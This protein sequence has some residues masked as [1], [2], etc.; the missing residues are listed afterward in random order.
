MKHLL[1]ALLFLLAAVTVTAQ[2]TLPYST[3][4]DGDTLD[5]W[6]FLNDPTNGWIHGDSVAFSGTRCLYVSNDGASHSYTYS[7]SGIASFSYAYTTVR[8]VQSGDHIVAY[9]WM[10]NGEVNYDFLRVF[11]VPDS[12]ELQAGSAPGITNSSLPYNFIALD[13]GSQLVNHSTWQYL[14]S[15][16]NVPDTGVYKL[17][18]YWHNDNSVGR[19]PPAAIDDL[20]FDFLTCH[21]PTALRLL[22]ASDSSLTLA[23]NPDINGEPQQWFL[24]I[25]DSLY[26]IDTNVVTLTGLGEDTLYNVDLYHYCGPGD[27][28][29]AITGSF[30]TLCAS[31][32][33][34]W[35]ED[36][37]VDTLGCWTLHDANAASGY[38]GIS[39]VNPYDGQQSLRLYPGTVSQPVF[40]V[41]PR[42]DGLDSLMVSFFLR[43]SAMIHVDVGIMANVLDT[44]TFLPVARIDAL[45][46]SGWQPYEVRLDGQPRTSGYLA[47]RFATSGSYGLSA[48]LDAVDVLPA[49]SCHGP[50]A[51]AIDSLGAQALRLHITD[52]A[53]DVSY[54]LTVFDSLDNP[55]VI[56]NATDTVVLLGGLTP[57]SSYLL[58][59][60]AQC[61]DNRL[62]PPL[63]VPFRTPSLI[64]VV[65]LDGPSLAFAGDTLLFTATLLD[66]STDSLSLVLHSL[67]LDTSLT[68]HSPRSMFHIAYPFGGLDTLTL[69]ATNLYG[70]ATAT[71]TLDVTE[72][73]VIDLFPHTEGFEN[74]NPCWTTLDN[75]GDGYTF[76]PLAD[77][78][79]PSNTLMASRSFSPAFPPHPLQPDNWLLSPYVQL[80]ADSA[81]LFWRDYSD[82]AYPAEH[83]TLYILPSPHAP[84]SVLF[85]T[86]LVEGGWDSRAVDLT[87]WLGQRVRFAFR[88]HGGDSQNLLGLD[89]ITFSHTSL[90]HP[91]PADTT[92]PHSVPRY[93][94]T[95]VAADS[96][97]GAVYGSGTYDS[98][99]IV[100]AS[101]IAGRGY[102]FDHWDD[103][104]TD[105]SR[106]ILLV[107]DSTLTATFRG[108]E[109]I[110]SPS[111]LHP[112]PF[113][114]YPNPATTDVTIKV[115][116]NQQAVVTL[117]DLH[118]R[119]VLPPTH[120]NATFIIPHSSL[121]PGVYLLRIVSD[122]GTAT[123]RLLVE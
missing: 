95:L 36:F 71:A 67:L 41:S 96:T 24:R 42:L 115:A 69:T 31:P 123:F 30:R 22:T 94:L 58:T 82:P 118:G 53:S 27:T 80:P 3:H 51:V 5:G 111:S 8:V 7:G 99:S 70:S 110:H 79:N 17:V 40:A 89:S 61:S 102:R 60:S 108:T 33:I 29:I 76:D 116:G 9:H 19:T 78:L 122:E 97:M 64:P 43:G 121:H 50:Q 32:G 75:D 90:Y 117:F 83:Y 49:P 112:S 47:F 10:D 72:C 100:I 120:F 119:T 113:S 15:V 48:Y 2:H 18:L 38:T 73:A 44:G 59:V 66:G 28:S 55:I 105:S 46:P 87:P 25:D 74:Y 57:S 81:T 37:E 86:T 1:T 13:G 91:D 35:H 68:L 45:D 84:L 4:F 106:A 54:R 34:P 12:V 11:L 92:G 65:S 109:S 101:A 98:A 14:T 88:H 21:L 104:S 63:V 107:S 56:L 39:L 103:G 20:S 77:P 62:T 114:L 23:W 85:D 16:V 26:S 52:T 6:Q 93:T